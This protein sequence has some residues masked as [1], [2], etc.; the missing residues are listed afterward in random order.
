MKHLPVAFSLSSL[1]SPSLL[2]VDNGL[3]LSLQLFLTLHLSTVNND[4]SSRREGGRGPSRRQSNGLSIPWPHSART[5][6]LESSPVFIFSGC[7]VCCVLLI[8]YN[9]Y[10]P[11]VHLHFSK[12]TKRQDSRGKADEG[13]CSRLKNRSRRISNI[14]SVL[15]GR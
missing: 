11:K 5:K 14:M 8:I 4:V 12:C 7:I 2:V 13:D 1:F 15:W 9:L 10:H 6:Q 3:S